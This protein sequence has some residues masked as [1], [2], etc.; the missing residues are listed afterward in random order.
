[1]IAQRLSVGTVPSVD[2]EFNEAANGDEQQDC[3]HDTD[4]CFAKYLEL[5]NSLSSSRPI[6]RKAAA[7][8]LPLLPTEP[9]PLQAGNVIIMSDPSISTSTSTRQHDNIGPD[10]N[11][12]II[13]VDVSAQDDKKDSST[14]PQYEISSRST[15]KD[16]EPNSI[17]TW[18]KEMDSNNGSHAVAAP[19]TKT[20]E[21]EEQSSWDARFSSTKSSHGFSKILGRV[22]RDI[23][24]IELDFDSLM[25]SILISDSNELTRLSSVGSDSALETFENLENGRLGEK[26]A[27]LILFE[28]FPMARIEWLN[29][30]KESFAPYDF[31]VYEGTDEEQIERYVEVKTR[32]KAGGINRWFISRQELIFAAKQCDSKS[33]Y[34]CLLLH[35]ERC[36][37]VS[38]GSNLPKTRGVHWVDN[39]MHSANAV[40]DKTSVKFFLQINTSTRTVPEVGVLA[41]LT[42]TDI[43]NDADANADED[44]DLNI[45]TDSEAEIKR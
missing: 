38:S 29:E 28:R 13:P 39:L 43:D 21:L 40:D 35:F 31:V 32:V 25:S 6:I 36:E 10:S 7:P 34:S 17:L 1:M 18:Q 24:S 44:V 5:Q 3:G 11:I 22:E 15:V 27:Q 14:T 30:H 4:L 41:T 16:E 23:E 37:P 20:H 42:N 45:S 9:E 26:F 8:P 19:G 2:G 12:D 33:R